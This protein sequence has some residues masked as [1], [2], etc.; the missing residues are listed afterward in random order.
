MACQQL[1]LLTLQLFQQFGAYFAAFQYVQQVRNSAEEGQCNGGF[2]QC[3]L[4]MGP[5]EPT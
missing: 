1:L 3:P 4:A 2:A 5:Q